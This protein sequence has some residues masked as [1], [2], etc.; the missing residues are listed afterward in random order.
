ML[1]HQ[2]GQRDNGRRDTVTSANTGS[3]VAEM[4]VPLAGE[5]VVGVPAVTAGGEPT[6]CLRGPGQQWHPPA[7][8]FGCLDVGDRQRTR[9]YISYDT[10]SGNSRSPPRAQRIATRRTHL[11][12]NRAPLAGPEVRGPAGPDANPIIAT[13]AQRRLWSAAWRSHHVRLRRGPRAG[14]ARG[15]P[16]P[17]RNQYR[18]AVRHDSNGTPGTSAIQHRPIYQELRH[19]RRRDAAK[20]PVQELNS[21]RSGR[22]VTLTPLTIGDRCP[23]RA[24]KSMA[25]EPPWGTITVNSRWSA[26]SVPPVLATGS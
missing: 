22:W 10:C 12:R 25:M 2:P 11:H 15:T 5:R 19:L 6:A 8:E 1:A 9:P 18:H 26:L 4:P 13:S 17:T 14:P 21:Y 7:D 23:G 16:H 3:G 24:P 20:H